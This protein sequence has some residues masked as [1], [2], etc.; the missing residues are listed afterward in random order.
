MFRF[1]EI[2]PTSLKE[3]SMALFIYN[4]QIKKERMQTFKLP[5]KERKKIQKCS[6]DIFCSDLIKWK[7]NKHKA[8][9]KLGRQTLD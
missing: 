8:V 4:K 1:F 7:E 3:E 9:A 5:K 6:K 2:I